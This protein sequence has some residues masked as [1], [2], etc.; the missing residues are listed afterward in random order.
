MEILT[1]VL[2]PGVYVIV[3]CRCNIS[4]LVI[5]A[6]NASIE[7]LCFPCQIHYTWKIYMHLHT[8]LHTIGLS[9]FPQACTQQIHV[10][11]CAVFTCNNCLPSFPTV[12][13]M[14]R[15]IL[16]DQINSS[17]YENCRS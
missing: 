1:G 17:A 2:M 6:K 12:V 10:Y 7:K 16:G 14:C 11:M 8:F 15:G 13:I 3:S 9:G 4:K 5:I